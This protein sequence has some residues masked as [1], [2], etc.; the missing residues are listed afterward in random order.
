M[1]DH[2]PNYPDILGH[3]TGGTRCNV[4]VVQMALAVHPFVVR[5]G[6]PFEAILLIQNAAD[7]NV[8]VT[9]N[10]RV[11][12][13]DAK[14]QKDRFVAER[15]R[16]V[17]GLR[18]AEV[19]YLVMPITCHADT[20]VSDDYKIGV[21]VSANPLDKPHRIRADKGIPFSPKQGDENFALLQ[22]L[23]FSTTWRTISNALE[24]GF[25][26]MP[27]RLGS[28]VD[29][30]PGWVSLWTPNDH[31]DEKNL[32]KNSR[33]DLK[34]VLP[35][36]T[37]QNVLHPLL[38]MT[39]KRFEA[40][41]YPLMPA[42]ALFITKL[43]TWI[44]ERA[45]LNDTA[46]TYSPIFSVAD[47]LENNESVDSDSPTLPEWARG[48]MRA[49]AQYP[50]AIEQPV[51]AITGLVYPSLVADAIPLAF[52]LIEQESGESLG[53]DDE[54]RQY[55]EK[56]VG[57]LKAKANSGMNFDHAYLPLIIAGIVICERVIETTEKLSES[58]RNINTALLDRYR[59]K[60][61]D[62]TIIFD[63][64]QR[65]I[66]RAMEQFDFMV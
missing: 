28:L 13:R 9:V 53:T 32:L 45:T 12:E 37:R 52:A 51:K 7:V 55:T 25:N 60:T 27:G 46:Y 40:I 20:A 50:Q 58:L 1:S 47:T 5:A 34:K 4:G 3:F 64:T 17:I 61:A 57:M 63:L 43:L 44:L 15:N 29:F 22:K 59:E 38:D 33:A 42:E 49:M 30:K 31:L 2:T 41:G 18:P 35:Q 14:K 21:S 19:G 56:V 11:P 10:L 65:M 16:V 26:V 66:D 39:H 6:R 24:A 48:L 62:N 23:R 54:I 36:L 8:D